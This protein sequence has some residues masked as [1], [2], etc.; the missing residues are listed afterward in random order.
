M[1]GLRAGCWVLR[2]VFLSA[3][4]FLAF[5]VSCGVGIIQ[6]LVGGRHVLRASGSECLIWRIGVA[7]V[8]KWWL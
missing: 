3:M 8:F 5:R 7:W 6:F 1:C 4:D 2:V